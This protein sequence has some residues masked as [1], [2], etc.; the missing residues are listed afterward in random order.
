MT[1]TV[2]P[3][4][5]FRFFFFSREESRMH[6]HVYASGREAKFWVEP[7]VELERNAGALFDTI[8]RSGA[9]LS[10]SVA[11]KSES[12]GRSTSAAEITHVSSRG[13][14]LLA[15]DREMFLSYG[16]FPWFKDA[17]IGQILNVEEPS[18][19][20]FYWPDLDIDLSVE[21]IEHPERFPLQSG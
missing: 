9:D 11:M 15:A 3:A 18:A 20:H 21:I 19:G 7:K 10:G 6:V 4:K 12:H 1:P 16:D 2:F 8:E 14:G 13:I 17:T 5:G